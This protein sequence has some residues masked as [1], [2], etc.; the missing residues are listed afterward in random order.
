MNA[1]TQPPQQYTQP[2]RKGKKA[3]RKNVDISEI[4]SGLE[5]L[6]DEILT[7][8]PVA[9]KTSEELFAIDTKGDAQTRKKYEK[10]HKPLKA[11]EII[12]QRSAVPAIDS[13]KR[14]ATNT[15]N[16]IL[17]SKRR[18]ADWVSR[19]EV[20]RLRQVAADGNRDV[21]GRYAQ[22]DEP[23]QDLWADVPVSQE[24]SKDKYG[25]LPKTKSKVAP[26]TIHR[27]PI[28]MTATGKL[29]PSLQIPKAGTSYNPSFNDWDELLTTAGEKELAAEKK[30]LQDLAAEE[31]KASRVAAAAKWRAEEEASSSSSDEGTEWEGIAS[32]H[33][34]AEKED[35]EM[36]QQKRPRR[37][38]PAERNRAKK[39][40][41]AERLAKHERKMAG[42]KRQGEDIVEAAREAREK[43]KKVIHDVEDRSAP[44]DKDNQREDEADDSAIRRRKLGNIAIPEKNLELVLPDELQ[45][46][47][48][49]LKPEGNLLGDR[50]RNLLVQGKIEARRPVTQPKKAKKTYTE[51]WSYKDFKLPPVA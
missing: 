6:R 8:G 14:P 44:E 2:S 17:P 33:E 20:A 12:A 16:G 3:W 43:K 36:L 31:E 19:K 22:E 23:A 15:G 47:L 42:R 48:R 34:G 30:R 9:E 35:A 26:S 50:F 49:R 46:S 1:A 38:T 11:E 18:K 25:Y 21:I 5:D 45:D 24:D 29:V 4:T 10:L 51:K 41:E 7:G 37:K 13:R 28:S 32:G 27:P 39:R 40:K